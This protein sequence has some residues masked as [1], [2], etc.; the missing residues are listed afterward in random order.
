MVNDFLDMFSATALS[1]PSIGQFILILLS[2]VVF[3]F[4]VS[5][6]Y[7]FSDKHR[8]P[9]RSQA[10]TLVI[11]PTIVTVI[12]MM[13]G[14]NLAAAL[15]LG[16]A[17]AIIRFRSVA[18]EPKDIA[19]ILFCMA[20]GLTSGTGLMLYALCVTIAL[21][22]V[23]FVLE[24]LRFAVLKRTFKTLKITIPENFNYQNAFD[25]I[26]QRYATDVVQKRVR[27]TDLGSLFEITFDVT[28]QNDVDEKAFIDELRARNGN[29]QVIL[30][31]G[32]S[33]AMPF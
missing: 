29:L 27:T 4:I 8:T 10:L 5:V 28:M 24:R 30:V 15:S 17:F 12:V 6:T 13:V 14:S 11:M 9:L 18:S 7:L 23:M 2:T 16:G 31:L 25:D 19:Y 26:F 33:N 21:C 1:L 20:I 22:L 3:G 32:E